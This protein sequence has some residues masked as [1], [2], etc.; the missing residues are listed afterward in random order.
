MRSGN[1][2]RGFPLFAFCSIITNIRRYCMEF[3]QVTEKVIYFRNEGELL[4]IEGWGKNSLRVQSSLMDQIPSGESALLPQEDRDVKIR[5]EDMRHAS[6]QNG[7]I[8]AE[9]F[10]QE[11]GN[12]LQI[13]FCDETGKV[14]LREIS[15]G[16]ALTR[17]ARFFQALPGGGY[18]LEASFGADTG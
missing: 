16:G 4:K 6:I 13:T 9:L 8:R 17:K 1:L 11:W 14:L 7:S 10:V 2:K 12:A 15:G 5:V 3:F 18:R